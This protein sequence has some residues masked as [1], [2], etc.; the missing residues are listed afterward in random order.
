M[1]LR[2]NV[3]REREA[4]LRIRAFPS[5]LAGMPTNRASNVFSDLVSNGQG[6][7][8]PEAVLLQQPAR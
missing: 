3:E 8:S 4:L 7:V 6:S 5:P 1:S 2:F